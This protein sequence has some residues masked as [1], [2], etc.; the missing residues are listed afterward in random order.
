MFNSIVVGGQIQRPTLDLADSV[1]S[2]RRI[3]ERGAYMYFR[4]KWSD[5]I[6]NWLLASR[7]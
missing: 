1:P 4:V 7:R 2:K 6:E 5:S 3:R